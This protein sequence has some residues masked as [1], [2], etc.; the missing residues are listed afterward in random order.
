[1]KRVFI[2][3]VIIIQAFCIPVNAMEFEAPEV[4]EFGEYYMPEDTQSF[5]QA[6]LELFQKAIQALLPELSKTA[7][8][9]FAIVAVMV[10]VSMVDTLSGFQHPTVNIAVT[11]LLG[12]ILLDPSD[13]LLKLGVETV[14]QLT[15][16]GKLLLPVLTGV[17]AAQGGVNTSAS[18]YAG[19]AIFSA[20][21]S[22]LITNLMIPMLYIFLCLSVINAAVREVLVENLLKFVKWLITWLL[23]IV[24]YVFTGFM[25]VTSV[26]SGAA[27]ASAVKVAK[28]TIAGMVPVVG[29]IISEASETILISAGYMKS[30][31]GIY[32]I[33]ALISILIGPFLKIGVQYLMLKATAAV[34]SVFTGHSTKLLNDFS[35][36]M[37]M[38]LG[39]TG[40]VCLLLLI[41]VVCFMK[42]VA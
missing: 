32:G 28:L 2:V 31:A 19:T 15:Q 27:D 16:Y 23:K 33:L 36:G 17:M 1:M 26:I 18:L 34:C 39:A 14:E 4:S 9:C 42:G 24:L 35:A 41:S 7:N 40:T 21:L 13:A 8:S 38:L 10:L 11:I 25:G 5:G 12:A 22:S 20:F 6:L 30:A 3:F 29:G 37:G